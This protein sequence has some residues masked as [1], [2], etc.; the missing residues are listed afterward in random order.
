MMFAGDSNLITNQPR[1][2]AFNVRPRRPSPTR[3]IGQR[4]EELLATAVANQA[5]EGH[6]LTPDEVAECRRRLRARHMTS[7]L[8]DSGR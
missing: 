7:P 2:G 4:L 3:L 5:A 1:S 8:C 6:V